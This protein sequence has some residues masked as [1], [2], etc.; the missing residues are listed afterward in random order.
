MHE[1]TTKELIEAL[2]EDFNRC[3][4][5]ILQSFDEGTIDANGLLDADYEFHARQLIRAAF[6][7]I[8]AVTFSVKITAAAD[9]LE[10]RVEIS[11]QE[12]S[13]AADVDYEVND[14]GVVVERHARIKL[15]RNIRFA[16]ALYERAHRIHPQFDASPE[17][18]SHLRQ[19]LKVRDRLMHPRMPEDLDISPK[20][21]VNTIKAKDGF[22]RL[23]LG[24]IS[25]KSKP[26]VRRRKSKPRK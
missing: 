21:I 8:E 5:N 10:K 12:R 7:Y 11:A 13:F 14:K 9:C 24:Y 3:Y 25:K 4:R 23:L 2:G 1:R 16:F 18:W 20:E 6:A 26:R 19:S 22:E 15:S 17:W